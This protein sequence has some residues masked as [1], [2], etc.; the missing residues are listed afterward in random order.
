MQLTGNNQQFSL[1]LLLI[2]AMLTWGLSWSNG[3]ILGGYPV[4]TTGLMFWRFSM[5]AAAMLFVLVLRRESLRL[6]RKS[7][8]ALVSGGLSLAI[9][10]YAYFRGTHLGLASVGGVLVTTLNPIVTL[11]LVLLVER[12]KANRLE[13]WGVILG[14]LGGTIILRIWEH[15]KATLVAS[16]NLF[17]LLCAVS[18]AF[19]TLISARMGEGMSYLVFSFWI[20]T[21]AAVLA[22]PGAIGSGLWTVFQQDAVFWIN[23]LSVSLGAMA[24][25]TTMY[26]LASMRLGSQRAAAF[27]F[28]VPLSDT[29]FSFFLLAEPLEPIILL[30]GSLSLLAV[31]LVNA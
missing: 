2:L 23:L 15:D 13:S 9:Y 16:G 8:I 5:A 12:R 29:L 7:F 6:E 4:A 30:G 24:F 21:V 20:Y 11:L 3:K 1:V 22:L 27:I 26:F 14:L 31:Y 17:F 19:L 18:W 25:A 28:M 10:N